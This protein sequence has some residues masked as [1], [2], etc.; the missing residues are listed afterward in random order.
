MRLTLYGKPDC[1]LCHELKAELLLLQ[2][3]F[4]FL[5]TERNIEE[6]PDDLARYRFLIPVLDFEDGPVH[7]PPHDMQAIRAALIAND[8]QGC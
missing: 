4:G 8:S 3:E 7:Y 1:H 5:L 2:E 6:S